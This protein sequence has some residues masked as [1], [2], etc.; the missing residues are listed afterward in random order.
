MPKIFDPNESIA[1]SHDL[2]SINLGTS[3]II[4]LIFLNICLLIMSNL[5]F[6]KPKVSH[7][8]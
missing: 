5:I 3:I 1:M 2:R 7:S 4:I 6:M 8:L